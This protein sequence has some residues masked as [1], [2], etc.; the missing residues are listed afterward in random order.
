MPRA[1]P[2]GNRHFVEVIRTE[3][4]GS[5]VN[6]AVHLLNDSWRDV[7]DC[8]VVVSNDS[9]LAEAMRL[10]KR[11]H[12]KRIGL[13]TPGTGKTSRELAA[14]ADF[15]RPVRRQALRRSQLPDPIPGTNIQKPARWPSP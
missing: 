7:Y 13:V 15:T 1:N 12:T 10:V 14:H 4:K 11:Q 5:D 3:E 2:V 6:L 9:D 8:A